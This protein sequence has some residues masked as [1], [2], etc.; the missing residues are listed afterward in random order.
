M[1]GSYSVQVLSLE[2][3]GFDEDIHSGLSAMQ[4]LTPCTL[5]VC[6]GL[7]VNCHLLQEEAILMMA[8]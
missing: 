8:E 6:P 1:F 4:T 2:G 7:C 5:S 3:E